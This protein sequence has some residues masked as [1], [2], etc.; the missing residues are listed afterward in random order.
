MPG[1]NPVFHKLVNDYAL[2]FRCTIC[3][4]P[5]RRVGRVGEAGAFEELLVCRETSPGIGM[6]R[7]L[8]SHFKEEGRV[9]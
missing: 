7:S 2:I 5:E 6:N 3:S 4:M 9:V 8:K 1:L